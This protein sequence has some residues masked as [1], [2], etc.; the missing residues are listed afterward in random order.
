[1]RC[2]DRWYNH[3][4]NECRNGTLSD[5]NYQLFHGTPTAVPMHRLTVSTCIP[6]FKDSSAQAAVVDK[7]TCDRN[8]SVQESGYY[9]PWAAKFLGKGLTGAELLKDECAA[10]AEFRVSN[11]RV[12][13]EADSYMAGLLRKLFD[14]AP[15]LYAFN[16]PRY[17]TLLMRAR[18]FARANGLRLFWTYARDVP[19]HR[20]D[21]DLPADQLHEKRCRWLGRHD[22]DTC[23]LASQVPLAKGLPVRLT[24]SI[25]RDLGLWRG[26]RG[27]VAGW[28]PHPDEEWEIVDGEILLSH[29]PLAIYIFFPGASWKVHESLEK[30]VYPLLSRSLT[31]K[32]HK[33][34]QVQ[35]R[36]T[37][38][39][40][41]PDFSSTAHM[42]QGQNLD[43]L[44][45]NIASGNFGQSISDE[46]Q[47]IGYVM[48]S[49][50]KFL[51]NV[52]VMQPFPQEL[53]T[54]GPPKGL[55]ILMEKLRGHITAEEAAARIEA[56]DRDAEQTKNK[57]DP[58]F[59]KH[60]CTHCFL[61]GRSEN[62]K[63]A[64]LFGANSPDEIYQQIIADGA[65]TRCLQCREIA[66]RAR[67]QAG[68][69]C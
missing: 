60:R 59:T 12:L 18:Q 51:Q 53:F 68:D 29:M 4:L 21:R 20:D 11:R 50:A 28:L 32:V 56:T 38:F 67:A 14:S 17:Y 33:K 55:H 47:A 3:F 6:F 13:Q 63:P 46:L 37:G 41:V 49:R 45:A 26:R 8:G 65:W 1:M 44:F 35:G 15:A 2:N 5:E 22:Q 43:A 69:I 19:L 16:V 54:A 58:L 61:A 48:L 57:T 64:K 39:C 31:W 40:T 34:S 7:C 27:V 24:D 42:I 25:D 9:Q 52:W 10:C 30:G 66:D 62:M 23:H 36:R